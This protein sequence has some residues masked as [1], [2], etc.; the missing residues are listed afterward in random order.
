MSKN[1]LKRLKSEAIGQIL[2]KLAENRDVTDQL[3]DISD[4]IYL[5]GAGDLG[6]LALEYCDLCG[7][8][9]IGLLDQNRKGEV[10]VGNRSVPIFDPLK[11]ST[12]GASSTPIFVAI[13][14]IPIQPIIDY[15]KLLGHRNVLPF[16]ALTHKPVSQH[17]LANG[18]RI[19]IVSEEEMADVREICEKFADDESLEHYESFISWHIDHSESTSINS[20]IRYAPSFVIP[21]IRSKLGQLVDVGSHE[22][23]MPIRFSNMGLNFKEYV[24]IEPDK[25]SRDELIVKASDLLR[26]TSRVVVLDNILSSKVGEIGFTQGLGYCSQIRHDI[27]PNSY[28]TTLDSLQLKP[29]LLK[30]HTEGSELEI[31][32]GG[33]QTIQ[34]HKPTIMFTV[35]H[36]RFGFTKSIVEPMRFFKGYVWFFRQHS[37]QGTGAVVYGIPKNRLFGK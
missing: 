34:Q 32:S 33:I 7:I 16:Y 1:R 4:G 28:S 37:F 27:E 26:H 5:Y 12:N 18:W 10:H 6:S 30:I 29:D 17:P 24:L 21:S 13:A 9:V 19:G 31:I 3:P 35:Y 23:Q 22:A 8:T 14:N 20:G 25:L 36:N 15:L 11:I 2:G